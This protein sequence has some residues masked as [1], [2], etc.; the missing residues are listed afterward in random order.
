MRARAFSGI[1][2]TPPPFGLE[3]SD[4]P[5]YGRLE[6]G[7]Y[8]RRGVAGSRPLFRPIGPSCGNSCQS[9][10]LKEMCVLRTAS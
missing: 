2:T 10:D 8:C 9:E 3:Q 1:C 6:E 7:A 4:V 5:V